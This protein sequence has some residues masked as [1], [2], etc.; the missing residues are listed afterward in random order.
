M[1]RDPFG[2]T[3]FDAPVETAVAQ[4]RLRGLAAHDVVRFL[5]VPY[6]MPPTDALRW[7]PPQPPSRWKGAF[8]AFRFGPIAPQPS[9]P[10]DPG[11]ADL[12]L[13]EDCLTL[14]VWAPRLVAGAPVMAWIH[15]GGLF[16]GAGSAPL[17]DGAALARRGVVVVTLNYRLGRLGFFEHPAL[18]AVRPAGEPSARYGLMDV[19]AALAWVKDNIGALGGDPDRVTVFGHSAGGLL[20]AQLMLA[21][22][23]R[24]LFQRAIIQSMP[25]EPP[26]KADGQRFLAEA[27]LE[28]PV[29][30]ERLRT[31]SVAS[32]MTPPP[33]FYGGDLL[34]R[35]D[36]LAD[37]GV[38]A[39]FAA[40]RQVDAPLIIGFTN[41]EFPTDAAV[42]ASAAQLAG[43][44]A[45]GRAD[46]V[47]KRL[48]ED[49]ARRLARLHAASGRAAYLYRF[50]GPGKDA[51]AHGAEREFVFGASRLGLRPPESDRL[52]D[53]MGE[54][55]TTFARTGDPNGAGRPQWPRVVS[56]GGPLMRLGAE[57]TQAG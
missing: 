39:G 40:G 25:L 51:A 43:N 19:I 36:S 41:A 26:S 56:D 20:I 18:A 6:A 33:D 52:V 50:E 15:G 44:S 3:A 34:W 53:R 54:Y 2:F 45:E 37:G 24:G 16:S 49:P 30:A 57:T 55:W 8:E 14:N 27:G 35:G 48:F 11:V 38:E 5:G 4:G 29:T 28:G 47:S 42:P 17:Y 13:S 23:A 21:P 9:A 7:R 32:L 12:P 1:V 31:L 22:A 46:Q 10:G